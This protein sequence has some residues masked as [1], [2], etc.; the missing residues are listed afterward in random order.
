MQRA[1]EKLEL[2]SALFD[3]W[4]FEYDFVDGKFY[5][6]SGDPADYGLRLIR[7]GDAVLIDKRT[8]HPDDLDEFT[9][10]CEEWEG[11]TPEDIERHFMEFR[12]MNGNDWKWRSITGVPSA[13]FDGAVTSF[14]AKVSDIDNEKREKLKLIDKAQRDSLT[15]L[16]NRE[17]FEAKV[18]RR[19]EKVR[20]GELERFAVLIVD[21]D[22][23]KHINDNYGHLFGD[24]SILDL[25]NLLKTHKYPTDIVGRFGG[26]EFIIA[27]TEFPDREELERKIICLKTEYSASMHKEY[28]ALPFSYSIGVAVFGPD[29]TDYGELVANADKALYYVKEHGKDGY[30]FCNQTIRN[31]FDAKSNVSQK[32]TPILVNDNMADELVQFALDLFESTNDIMSAVGLLLGRIGRRYKLSFVALRERMQNGSSKVSYTWFSE[33]TQKDLQVN[34]PISAEDTVTTD[35]M[36]NSSESIVSCDTNEMDPTSPFTRLMNAEGV[37]AF[38]KSPLLSGSEGIGCVLF[39]VR[40]GTREWTDDEIKSFAVVSRILSVYIVREKG[41]DKAQKEIERMMNYDD[42]TTLLK[43][44]KFKEAAGQIIVE[45]PGDTYAVISADI[46]HFKYFNEHYGFKLGDDLLRDF[47]D[48]IVKH[49]PK[50]VASCR[51]YADNFLLLAR[52]TQPDALQSILEG[53]SKRFTMN[54]TIRFPETGAEVNAGYY[55][56][57]EDR[58][59]ISVAID[60][61][62]SAKKTQ[63]ETGAAGVL[64][65]EKGMKEGK[66]H[67]VTLIHTIEDALENQEFRP[68]L[69][70]KVSL[71][72][73][74]VVGAEAL[75]RWLKPDGTIGMPDEYVPLLEKCGKILNLD[76]YVFECILRLLKRW[77][78]EGR[79]LIPI[80]VNFSR[81]HIKNNLFVSYLT[82]QTD[83]Y[84]IDRKNIEIEITESAFVDDSDALIRIMNE[85]SALGFKLAVDDF[86]KGYSSLSML[87]EVPADAIKID[88][89]F[90]KNY[91]DVSQKAMLNNVVRLI[92]DVSMTVVCEGIEE[93]EQAEF[94]ALIGCDEGQ[95]FWFG[96]P[97]PV[98]EFEI[99][100]NNKIKSTISGI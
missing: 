75:V 43:F 93:K 7:N 32:R 35:R 88:K 39:G 44:D 72:T 16:Y 34:T 89:E 14:V 60:N 69:Q 66:I 22:N 78:T 9:K 21:I 33:D 53:Y 20:R 63:K 67:E 68:F 36:F 91:Q 54:E 58:V 77:E 62:N 95:G 79:E 99:R 28:E 73:G 30:S 19:L 100:F 18:N 86:G 82:R 24:L 23:F 48:I 26:D 57:E 1:R 25:T 31:T 47:A 98:S 40:T 29:G 6:L 50:V 70:P 45:N 61:A 65:F 3:D 76:Y 96:K 2:I 51:E 27:T 10:V 71:T 37:K 94:L 49:N 83:L 81:R 4:I 11:E 55:L 56:I 80:S 84:G 15:G 42:V 12:V 90:L 38:V 92:K 97:M 5:T 17:A 8:I 41:Y 87:N 85:I 59:E 52:V 46:A 13:F 64:R 74:E